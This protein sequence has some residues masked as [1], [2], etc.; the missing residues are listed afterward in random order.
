[1]PS[2]AVAL[3]GAIASFGCTP[4]QSVGFAALATCGFASMV[5]EGKVQSSTR[6]S[7]GVEPWMAVDARAATRLVPAAL[8]LPCHMM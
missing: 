4:S 5:H 2:C 6:G 3:R 8:P 7:G 1:M